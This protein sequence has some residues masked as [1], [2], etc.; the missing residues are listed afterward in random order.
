MENLSRILMRV[1]C[2]GTAEV[3]F[4]AVTRVVGGGSMKVR[5]GINGFGRMGRLVLRAGWHSPQLDFVHINETEGG[6]EVAAHLL[7]FDSVHGR[8]DREVTAGDKHIHIEDKKIGFSNDTF[9]GAVPWD[10]RRVDLVLE[11]SGK[12]RT[13]PSLAPYFERGVQKVIVA[14]PVKEGALNIVVGVN[15]HEY[16]PE[17]H[18]I[19]TAAS[20]TTNCL[21]PVVKVIH[22]GIGIKHGV[23]TTAVHSYLI[24]AYTEGDKV[25]LNVGFYYMANAGGRLAGTVLSGLLFQVYGLVGC[26]WASVAFV[27]AAGLLAWWLP[28]TQE[29]K[30]IPVGAVASEDS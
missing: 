16:R 25:A 12:F 22:E 17:Q 15:D 28:H 6:P 18:H 9:P 27:L 20:C 4:G 11:C 19:L 7:K 29:P 21:A 2:N 24:L 8:W 23:I 3:V 1:I 5:V 26:L 14:A 13:A 10:D 30:L